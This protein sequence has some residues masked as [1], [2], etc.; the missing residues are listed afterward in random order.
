MCAIL[1]FGY[2]LGKGAARM[3]EGKIMTC[4]KTCAVCVCGRA[5]KVRTLAAN[6]NFK[7]SVRPDKVKRKS[8]REAALDAALR[9]KGSMQ[10]LA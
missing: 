7:P 6:G 1:N 8:F 4:H 3:T 10:I 2:F 9:Y 5:G